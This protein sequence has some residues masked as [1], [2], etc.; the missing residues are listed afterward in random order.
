MI[1][2]PD[3]ICPGQNVTYECTVVGGL[4]TVWGGSVMGT[5]CEITLF[6][7][8]PGS[9]TICNNGA[10]VGRGVEV[11]N[12]C[13][14]SQLTI[15]LTPDLNQRT[16]QCSVDTGVEEFSIGRAQLLLITGYR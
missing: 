14:T 13:F 9:Y 4:L 5:G 10:V 3:C 1:D 16:I 2:T 15:L 7:G 11:N 8:Y 12:N 6:H